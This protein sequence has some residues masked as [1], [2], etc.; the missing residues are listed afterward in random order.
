M[1]V[2]ARASMNDIWK[3]SCLP[4]QRPSCASCIQSPT[5]ACLSWNVANL[6]KDSPC[7]G[8]G[9][10]SVLPRRYAQVAASRAQVCQLSKPHPDPSPELLH[11]VANRQSI[12]GR[13]DPDSLSAIWSRP[14]RQVSQPADVT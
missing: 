6:P 11:P 5:T 3:L 7:T 10:P 2:A 4:G 1:Q 13:Y 12:S 8:T 14:V 9:A